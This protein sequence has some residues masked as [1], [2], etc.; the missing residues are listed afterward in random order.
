MWTSMISG[1]F[2]AAD[3]KEEGGEE[4]VAAAAAGSDVINEVNSLYCYDF[5]LQG[6]ENFRTPCL[7]LYSEGE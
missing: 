2:A 6:K 4:A 3:N 5:I 1:L 7:F